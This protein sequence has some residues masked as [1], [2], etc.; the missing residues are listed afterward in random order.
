MFDEVLCF[1]A[2]L[3]KIS[4]FFDVDLAE[5]SRYARARLGNIILVVQVGFAV[6][7]PLKAVNDDLVAVS[8]LLK[9]G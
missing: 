1:L 2:F 3:F 5:Y 9:D 7:L 8:G 4:Q 6:N